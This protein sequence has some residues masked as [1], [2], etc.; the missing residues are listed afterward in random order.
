MLVLE[1]FKNEK[2][3]NYLFNNFNPRYFV[4]H[5]MDVSRLSSR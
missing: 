1:I 2:N 3:R 4:G 5:T